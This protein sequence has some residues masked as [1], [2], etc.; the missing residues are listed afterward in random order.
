MGEKCSLEYKKKIASKV[1][2][3]MLS[4]DGYFK[5]LGFNTSKEAQLYFTYEMKVYLEGE[6]ISSVFINNAMEILDSSFKSEWLGQIL[7][8]Y[9]SEKIFSLKLYMNKN[10]N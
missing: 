4:T 2:E 1:I 10:F 5:A 3:K 6:N 9:T 7:Q 8:L